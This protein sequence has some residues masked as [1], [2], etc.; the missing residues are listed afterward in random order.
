[1]NRNS[2][3][4][5]TSELSARTGNG[6][7]EGHEQLV[8][9]GRGL[10]RV[11][12]WSG[13]RWTGASRPCGAAGFSLLELVVAMTVFL[14]VSAASFTLFSRHETLL[15]QTQGI[16][17]L[18]IGLRNALSQIQMDVVNAGSGVIQGPNVPAWPVGVTIIN[19]NPT[20]AQCNPSATTPATYAAACFDQLNVVTVDTTTPPIQPTNSCTGSEFDTSAGTTLAAT[21]ANPSTGTQLTAAQVAAKYFTG[22][23][24]LFVQ[25]ESPYNYTTAVL[26]ANGTSSGSNVQ[27]TFS[28]TL[29]VSVNYP[30]GGNN[31]PGSNGNPPAN[32]P[33]SMTVYAPGSEVTRIYC[34]TDFVLRML[35]IS[36]S[37]SVA[38]AS[39]PQL[40][41]TQAGTTNTVMDQVIGFKVGAAWK[42]SNISESTVS[43]NY[44]TV[45]YIS[46]AAFP[47]NGSWNNQTIMIND[48]SFTVASVQP[49]ANPPTITLASGQDAGWQTNVILNGPI[50][51][52]YTYDYLNTDYNSDYTL[53]RAVRVTLIGRTTP[54]TDPTYLYR[55]PFDLGAYQIRGGS[56]IVNPRNL[57]MNDF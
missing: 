44:E 41:R 13:P 28:P 18:N 38:N 55:N 27:L 46:G 29:G 43:T 16:A 7:P 53:L 25:G 49:S 26:T 20:T 31:S 47:S 45:T 8:P 40:T 56:I 2:P 6:P 30:N 23:K 42:N 52:T 35:P 1:M 4:G 33:I 48:S 36:Y 12:S 37:V 15:S 14:V 24:I 17:G 19:S 51:Q 3:K 5:R 39:D 50:T 57:S 32:D 9:M 10:A 21:V 11:K 54:S 22:D 34:S